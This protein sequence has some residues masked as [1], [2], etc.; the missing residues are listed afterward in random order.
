V[1]TY[2]VIIAGYGPVG[3]M[4]GLLLKEQGLSALII[5]KDTVVQQFP[6]AAHFDD[7]VIRA[8]Q[9]VGLA[10]LS[11]VMENPP[12]Y[13]YFDKQ[14]RP[15]LA[16]EFP[17]GISNQSYKYDFMFYQPDVERAMRERL[18]EGPGAPDVLL[19]TTIASVAQDADG[20]TVTTS[21][22]ETHRGRWLIGCDGASSLVRK[23]MRGTTFEQISES[24]QWY[25]VDLVLTADADPGPDQF[26]YCDPERIVTFILLSGR[27]RRFEFDVKP[28]ESHEELETLER[29]QELLAPWLKPGEYQLLR[30]DVYKFHSLVADGWRD[31]RFL[32]AGDSAHLMTP[33]L[34]QGLCSGIRDT[35]NLAWKLERVIRG[36]APEAILDT[37]E[38][39]RKPAAREYVEISAY[40]VDQIISKAEGEEAQEVVEQIKAP[41]QKIGADALRAHDDLVGTLSWQPTLA[42]GTKLDESVGYRF[43]LVVTPGLADGLTADDRAALLA[44]G[45][46]VV[47]AVD[48]A[49]AGY[50]GEFS[51]EAILIRPDRYV[52]GSATDAESLS[53]LLA[54]AA[55]AYAVALPA[56]A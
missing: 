7:E 35:M 13:Q 22:G 44:L 28:G 49:L 34:G 48:P 18:E 10:H 26:E 50:L 41:R 16:R 23:S 42:D 20:V 40:M 5:E 29:T 39:E 30:N 36:T 17:K 2:D 19:G 56:L 9:A 51:R 33:K 46:V 4:M 14:W 38:V 55:A 25:V 47:R 12:V 31:E 8:Y 11:D 15:F 54:R 27:Y 52:E 32:I 21:T 24:R 43:G 45:C 53:A 37:Y 6:R 1:I 3:S